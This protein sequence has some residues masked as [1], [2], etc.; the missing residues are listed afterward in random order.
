MIT[1]VFSGCERRDMLLRASPTR[2]EVF[3]RHGSFLGKVEMS[4]TYKRG[5]DLADPILARSCSFFS[6]GSLLSMLLLE[7]SPMP[8]GA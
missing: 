7:V 8:P 3:L 2:M 4:S 6:S 5:S 1:S